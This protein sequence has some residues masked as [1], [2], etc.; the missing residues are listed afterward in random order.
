TSPIVT[1]DTPVTRA[2]EAL[3]FPWPHAPQAMTG[4]LRF[5]ERGAIAY[6]D[7]RVLFQIG[8]GGVQPRL[9]VAQQ[10]GEGHYRVFLS[11]GV[12][13]ASVLPATPV[14]VIGDQVELLWRLYA[15]GSVRIE[16]SINGG[17]PVVAARTAAIGL[18]TAWSGQIMRLSGAPNS[19]GN[20]GPAAWRDA[21]VLKGSDWTWDDLR[22]IVGA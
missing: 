20:E 2:A 14:P 1:A 13:V 18:P 11:Y 22:S 12:G 5:V 9:L 6:S 19:S 21:V 4:Y 7:T 15:D 8:T 3:S 16:Q 10:A 17:T